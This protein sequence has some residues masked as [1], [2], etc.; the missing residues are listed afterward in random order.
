MSSAC[1]SDFHFFLGPQARR[2]LLKTSRLLG[3]Q[4]DL[5]IARCAVPWGAMSPTVKLDFHFFLGPPA[6]RV[7][8]KTSR[9]YGAQA[10]LHIVS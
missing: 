5:H 2:V 6:R 8:L 10:D 7:S 9:L 3:V 4:G 1:G